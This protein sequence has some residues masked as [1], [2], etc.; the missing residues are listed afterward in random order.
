MAQTEP[1]DLD[2]LAGE[3]VLGTL[4]AEERLV[5]ERRLAGDA[6]F[7]AAVAA[8]EARLQPLSDSAGERAPPPGLFGRVMASLGDGATPNVVA[9]RRAMRRWRAATYAAAAIAA[10]LLAVVVVDRT[11]LPVATTRYVATLTSDGESPAFVLTVDTK[12]NT[13]TIRRVGEAAPPDN[14]YELWAVEPGAKPKS[15][16]LVEQASA[17]R[18]LPYS[19]NDLVLAVSLEPK[20]GSPTGV[21]TKVV[22]SGPLVRT[23]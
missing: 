14:S 8:W 21:P 22:F 2:G 5:A 11:V 20:G 10:V 13:L 1:D 23:N 6:T 9:L 18:T 4:S 12:S 16:G 17:T 15:L 19:P 3:Y 7:R